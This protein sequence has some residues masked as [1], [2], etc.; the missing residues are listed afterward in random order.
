MNIRTIISETIKSFIVEI[1]TATAKHYRYNVIDDSGGEYNYTF[2]TDSGLDYEVVIYEDDTH[3][4]TIDVTFY[5]TNLNKPNDT[6]T[7]TNRGE[8]FKVMATITQIIKDLTDTINVKFIR[9]TPTK[10][11]DNDNLEETQRFKLYMAYIKNMF[12]NAKAQKLYDKG[13]AYI[14]IELN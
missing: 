5:V 6:V 7:V 9:F 12:P 11:S 14:L 13:I 10:K 8:M 2:T 4:D 1:G 3:S